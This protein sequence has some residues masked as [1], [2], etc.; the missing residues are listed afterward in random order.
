MNIRALFE[1]CSLQLAACSL[2]LAVAFAVAL[3][4]PVRFTYVF[5]MQ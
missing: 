4:S 2:Q 5:S 1:A 3:A